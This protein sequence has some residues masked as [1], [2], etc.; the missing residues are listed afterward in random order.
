MQHNYELENLTIKDVKTL[1]ALFLLKDALTVLEPSK[2]VY[3]LPVTYTEGWTINYVETSVDTYKDI[4]ALAA[5][6]KNDIS[7]VNAMNEGLQVFNYKATKDYTEYAVICNGIM[8]TFS[9]ENKTYFA[10]SFMKGLTTSIITCDL[11]SDIKTK[12]EAEKYRANIESNKDKLKENEK[13]LTRFIAEANIEFAQNKIPVHL[14][15][16]LNAAKTYIDVMVMFK[17]IEDGKL[18][19]P[20]N[21]SLSW[22]KIYLKRRLFFTLSIREFSGTIVVYNEVRTPDKRAEVSDFISQCNLLSDNLREY[23]Q[24]IKIL[25]ELCNKYSLTFKLS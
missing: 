3:V 14:K 21:S 19:S 10:N 15:Y 9:D 23:G 7:L 16:K 13:A 18:I 24:I 2:P 17:D 12:E 6:L 4:W 5:P 25:E 22:D 1:D 11:N 20:N 8:Y